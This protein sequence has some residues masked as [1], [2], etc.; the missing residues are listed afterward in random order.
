M[1]G[2]DE[3]IVR[4]EKSNVLF[5]IEK[6]FIWH[7]VDSNTRVGL[8]VLHRGRPWV[9]DRGTHRRYSIY[10]FHVMSGTPTASVSRVSG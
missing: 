7:A 1:G 5:E 8:L 2:R 3:A 9:A 4:Q 6:C 10:S